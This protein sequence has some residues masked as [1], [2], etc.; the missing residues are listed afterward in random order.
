MFLLFRDASES[1]FELVFYNPYLAQGSWG[2]YA[3]SL[4]GTPC[5]FA[6]K[7]LACLKG[8]FLG[9]DWG[10]GVFLEAGKAGATWRLGLHRGPQ[11]A[12]NDAVLWDEERQLGTGPVGWGQLV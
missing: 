7:G 5:S 1:I 9:L 10:V 4:Q 8:S 12:Q 2:C 3:R 6:L 11:L